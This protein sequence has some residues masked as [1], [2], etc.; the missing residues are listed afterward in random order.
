MNHLRIAFVTF[1][2]TPLSAQQAPD[3]GP[4]AFRLLD[5]AA[6]TGNAC[7]SPWSLAA[8]L[9]MAHA[10]AAG[11]TAREMDTTLGLDAAAWRALMRAKMAPDT[12]T[13]YVDGKA[14]R[15]PAYELLLANAAWAR[16][17]QT[18]VPAYLDVLT[19]FA[20]PLR[21]ADFTTDAARTTIN[22]WVAEQTKNRIPELF[23]PGSLPRESRLALVNCVYLNAPW[24]EPFDATVTATASFHIAAGDTVEV[25]T[26]RRTGEMGYL[27][28][29]HAHFVDLPFRGGDLSMLFVVPKDLDGEARARAD[30]AAKWPTGGKLASRLVHLQVPRF[31]LAPTYGLVPALQKLGIGSAFDKERADF[32]GMTGGRDLYVTTVIQ[33]TFIKVDEKST[34]AAAA[35]GAVL[36]PT[37]A[38]ARE[39]EQPVVVR[40]DRPFLFVIHQRRSGAI[41]F[42]GR[43]SDPR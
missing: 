18:F 8:A 25:D 11:D 34:E 35:T 19:Q 36:G 31:E 20:A 30:L 16:P 1:L 41:L 26:M 42:I 29:Q 15:V 28:S 13:D 2:M 4:F 39:P 7:L 14:L 5:A 24:Q 32:S 21:R 6:P 37:A 12:V 33:K 43:V 40:A 38:V 10:G 27:A 22:G 9:A 3:L 23:A 17:E